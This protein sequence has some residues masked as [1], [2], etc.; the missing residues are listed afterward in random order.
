VASE[1]GQHC[2]ATGVAAAR[3][4][5]SARGQEGLLGRVDQLKRLGGTADAR[6]Q[7]GQQVLGIG[8]VAEVGRLEVGPHCRRVGGGTLAELGD[9]DHVTPG[10]A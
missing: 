5:R 2:D 8:V 4:A 6:R 3:V 10:Q 7:F 1:G 9:V